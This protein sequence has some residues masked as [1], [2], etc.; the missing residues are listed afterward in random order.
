MKSKGLLLLIMLNIAIMSTIGIKFERKL[1][2]SID[3]GGDIRVHFSH[4]SKKLMKPNRAL[5]TNSITDASDKSKVD[6]LSGIF[7]NSVQQI[8]SKTKRIDV[9]YVLN[10]FKLLTRI[11]KLFLVLYEVHGHIGASNARILII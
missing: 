4:G 9:V 5:G 10:S 8:R 6:V 11:L 3:T 2:Q 7:R 1:L